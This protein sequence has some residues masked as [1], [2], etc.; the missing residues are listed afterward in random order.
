MQLEGY[1]A[2]DLG[3]GCARVACHHCGMIWRIPWIVLRNGE[4][5]ARKFLDL[6][7]KNHVRE[8]ERAR[9][10]RQAQEGEA[11]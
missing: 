1:T 3:K 5:Q 6:H 11:K 8:A 7:W 2:V 4:S 9:Q 10:A